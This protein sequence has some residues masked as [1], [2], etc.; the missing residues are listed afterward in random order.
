MH[1]TGFVQGG[2][3]LQALPRGTFESYKFLNLLKLQHV[4]QIAA[5]IQ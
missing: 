2:F 4:P 5:C 1:L 3:Q